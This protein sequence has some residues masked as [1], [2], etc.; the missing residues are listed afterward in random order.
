MWLLAAALACAVAGLGAQSAFA[1][2]TVA[3]W[4]IGETSGTQMF[5]SARSHTGAL[6]SVALGLPGFTGTAYG[7]NGSSS[8]VSV[9]SASDLNPGSA[10]LTVKIHL[11]TTYQP[12]PE[13]RDLIR[14][15]VYS[16][17]GGEWK[18]EYYP[19][20]Q[21]SCGFKGSAGYT[22][23]KA[24]P[25]LNDGRWHTIKYVKTS[26]ALRVVVDGV[27]YSQPAILGSMANTV[28][29]VIGAHPGSEFF[30]G[31]LDEAS[32]AIG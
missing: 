24:G 12:P 27:A 14:K 7:F 18:V 25:A 32:I 21:A 29:L 31:S 13:D 26:S 4:H 1:Q 11:K 16:T 17:S 3:L 19:S 6:H 23:L 28:A 22:E 9:P 20:G 5:D 15:G 10:N 2:T 30:K 8:Y